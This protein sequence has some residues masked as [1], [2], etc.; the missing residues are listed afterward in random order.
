MITTKLSESKVLNDS[1][2]LRRFLQVGVC[3]SANA[4][5]T[6]DSMVA[7]GKFSREV[8]TCLHRR[9]SNPH[10]LSSHTLIISNAISALTMLLMTTK[11]STKTSLLIALGLNFSIPI[12]RWKPQITVSGQF[13]YLLAETSWQTTF[14]Q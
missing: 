11:P 9:P 2:S 4:S 7:L 8:S 14:V 6:L 12:Y 1:D 3:A 13:F 5:S 10:T